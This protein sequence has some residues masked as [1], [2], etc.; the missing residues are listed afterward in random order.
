MFNKNTIKSSNVTRSEAVK[1]IFES[2]KEEKASMDKI[3]AL[4]EEIIKNATALGL[5]KE[6]IQDI[7]N[8]VDS[9]K[10]SIND[11]NTVLQ[12]KLQLFIKNGASTLINLDDYK[13]II[14]IS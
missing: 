6:E 13:D 3:V 7:Q 4:E 8:S 9:M 1:E 11:L 10:E 14:D 12:N 5:S 2:V